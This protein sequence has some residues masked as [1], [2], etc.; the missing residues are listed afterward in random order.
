MST[1]ILLHAHDILTV[2]GLAL[3]DLAEEFL[4]MAP[5]LH[6]CLGPDVFLYFFP[7][8]PVKPQG[9]NKPRVLLLRPTL[10]RLGKRVVLACL[11]RTEGLEHTLQ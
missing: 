4:C 9:L 3:F 8:P 2:V 6:G 11:C 10:S 1:Q 5:D 7:T